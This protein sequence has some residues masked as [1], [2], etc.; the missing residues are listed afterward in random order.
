MEK[1]KNRGILITIFVAIGIF[2]LSILPSDLGGKQHV[3][4]FPGMDKVI[5]IIMYATLTFFSLNEYRL[6]NN[7]RIRAFFLILSIVWG[8]S[9]L[10]ELIQ[11]YFINSRSG[12]ILDAFANLGGI[13]IIAI[14]MIVSGKIKF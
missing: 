14:F 4:L 5:H 12:D 11:Y 6:R 2:I 1:Y 7:H 10:M 13:A 3:L 9:I 8:Y